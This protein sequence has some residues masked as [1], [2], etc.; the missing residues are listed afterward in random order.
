MSISSTASARE[1]SGLEIVSVNGYRLQTTME[2]GEIDCAFR[3][4]SSEGIERA[5]IP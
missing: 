2:M 3:S 4:C 5:R 1:Q